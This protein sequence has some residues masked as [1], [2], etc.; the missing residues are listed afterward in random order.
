VTES[1]QL[2]S[3]FPESL[4]IAMGTGTLQEIF[5]RRMKWLFKL[6]FAISSVKKG[7]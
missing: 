1:Q 4:P 6:E 7:I 5:I 2:N 3:L